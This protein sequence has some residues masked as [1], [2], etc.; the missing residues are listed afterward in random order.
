MYNPPDYYEMDALLTDEHKM[1]RAAVREWVNRNVKPIIEDYAQQHKPLPAEMMRQ[2]G[3]LGAMGITGDFP[4]MR[5]MMNLESVIT[6][7][8]THD[9]H[10]LIT[11]MDITE[12]SAFL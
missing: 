1:I 12:I 7:E 9:I 11:G 2:M 10:L 6:Y 8:G 5:H 4:I 3:E